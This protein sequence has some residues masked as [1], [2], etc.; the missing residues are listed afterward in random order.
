[1][2]WEEEE[3]SYPQILSCKSFISGFHNADK[4]FNVYKKSWGK[5]IPDS[6]RN[7]NGCKLIMSVS[8]FFATTALNQHSSRQWCD[9]S[10]FQCNQL[11]SPEVRGDPDGR[12][13]TRLLLLRREPHCGRGWR[14]Q[15]ERLETEYERDKWSWKVARDEKTEGKERIRKQNKGRQE[16]K[17]VHKRGAGRFWF[18]PPIFS[19]NSA[20][21]LSFCSYTTYKE[22]GP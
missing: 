3:A 15:V 16:K 8:F 11:L 6:L 13:S 2:D 17:K 14:E 7:G 9:T 12:H 19:Q 21:F 10:D 1:M 22:T 20:Y 18:L 5:F 4:H